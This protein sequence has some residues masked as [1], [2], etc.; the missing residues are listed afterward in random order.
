MIDAPETWLDAAARLGAAALLGGAIGWDRQKQGRA[1]GLR[2]H[3]MVAL[4]SAAFILVGMEIFATGVDQS[5]QVQFDAGRVIQGIAGGVGFLGA[6]AIIHSGGKVQG[7]TTAAGMW[8][9]AAMGLAAGAGLYPSALLITFMC[10]LILTVVR[11]IEPRNQQ[12]QADSQGKQ[13]NADGDTR[14]DVSPPNG[15]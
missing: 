9:C 12:D 1:A 14:V 11:W 5:G 4:G 6:G 8:A 2:T 13:G 3:M 10:I 7:L 15:S